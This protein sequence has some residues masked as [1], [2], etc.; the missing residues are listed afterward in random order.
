MQVIGCNLKNDR[1]NS[2]PFQGKPLNIIVIK[3]CAPKVMMKQMK[4][5]GS[6]KTY[7]ILE[8]EHSKKMSFSL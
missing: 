8:N 3:V 2:V 7:K 4:S 5:N 6:M 1:I